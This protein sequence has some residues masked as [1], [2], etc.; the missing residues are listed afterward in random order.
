[1]PDF[2]EL[3]RYLH[4]IRIAHHICGRIRLKLVVR[5]V[6]LELSRTQ[7]R[8]FQT[9]LATTPGVRSV[10]INVLARSC[11][12]HYDPSVIPESAWSDLLS[13]TASDAAGILKSILYDTYQEIVDEEL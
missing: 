12:V 11:T 10:D 4:N 2:E 1:M 13:S 3:R 6:S 5:P 9:L 8:A 7:A